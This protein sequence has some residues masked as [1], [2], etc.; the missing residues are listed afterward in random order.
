[1]TSLRTRIPAPRTPSSAA[2]RGGRCTTQRTPL[3][4]T[5][6]SQLYGWAHL[7]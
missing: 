3:P 2:R 4:T 7:R 1:M 6:T 5:T